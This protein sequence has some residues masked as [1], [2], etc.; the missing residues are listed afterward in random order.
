MVEVVRNATLAVGTTPVVVSSDLLIAQRKVFV[1][2]NTSTGGQ[3]ITL[4]WGQEVAA[5]SGIVLTPMGS[6]SESIDNAFF[7]NPLQI[8]AV[9]SGAGGVLS[10]HE[11]IETSK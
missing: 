6:W 7:P 1:A 8:Y 11:R 9:S 4:S 3:T 10:L 5:G 2:T